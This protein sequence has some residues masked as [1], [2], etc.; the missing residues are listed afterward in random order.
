MDVTISRLRDE[1]PG[2][3]GP[4]RLPTLTRLG[5]E[6]AN[7]YM[8]TGPGLPAA[9]PDLSA[10]IE[11][12]REAYGLLGGA[13]P[14]R[15][16]SAGQLGNLLAY[17]FALHGT[18]SEDRDTA[19]AMLGEAL[20]SGD[21]P[22][23]HTMV[24]QLQLGQLHLTY[25]TES[26]SPTAVRGCFFGGLPDSAKTGA[27]EAISC[28][29]A[30][31]DGPPIS[32]DVTA[33]ARALL[34]VAESIQP[35]LAGDL[36]RFDTSKIMDAMAQLQRLRRD[37]LP[38]LPGMAAGSGLV[39]SVAMPFSLGTTVDPIDYPV[40][41]IHGDAGQPPTVPAR[42][43][44]STDP[45]T[46]HDP[47]T[48]HDPVTA[49]DP[50]AR[51]VVRARLAALTDDAARPVWEQALDLLY[52]DPEAVPPGDLDTFVGAAAG[53]VDGTFADPVA[54]AV[55]DPI[56][57]GLDRLL[58]AVGLCA[59]HRRDGDGDGWG[60][61]DRD[62]WSGV[63]DDS[64]ASG[65]RLTAAKQLRAAA[66]LIPATHP[67]AAVVVTALGGLADDARPLSGPT[68]EIADPL[69]RY[70]D[71]IPD[72][73]A[74]VTAIGELCRTVTA[75][76]TGTTLDPEPFAAAVAALPTD[77]P[78][79]RQLSTAV[80]HARLAVA[81]R[82]GDA[83][84]V[85]AELATATAPAGLAALLEAVVRDDMATL[86]TAVDAITASP[87]RPTTRI[88]AIIGAVRLELAIRA[89]DPGGGDVTAAI[90]LLTTA[91]QALDDIADEGLRTRTWWRL[92]AAYRCRGDAG[93]SELCR[94]AGRHALRGAGRYPRRAARYAGWMLAE[95]HATEAFAALE[96]TAAMSGRADV[97]SL[98][99]D[100][101]SV[102]VGVAPQVTGPVTVPTPAEA[103][104]A[105]REI[106][107][108]SLLYLH[109]T[110]DA[111]RNAAALCVDPATDR[112]DVLANVPVTD[113]LAS[114][115][116]G[117]PAIVGRWT[118]GSLLLAST[119]GLERIALPAVRTGDNQ[120]LTQGVV[121]S[122]VSSGAEAITL[123]ARPA[124]AVDAAPL[125]VVNPRGD[126]DADMVE[127]LTLRRLFYP[128]SVCLGRALEPADAAGTRGELLARMPGASMVHLAC[129]LRRDGRTELQLADDDVLTA[130]AIRSLARTVGGGL[131]VLAEPGPDGFHADADVF[132]DAGFA[133]VI[134]WRWP[135]PAPFAALA[136]FMTHLMLVDHRLPP[137]AAVAAV[138][139]WMLD[140]DRSLPQ[141]VTT[142]QLHTV[143]TIDLTRPSFWAALACRGR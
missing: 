92:A 121:V 113:P 40:T 103:A 45:V 82:A 129:G 50:T 57:S 51:Q 31:V 64:S 15:G 4:A 61:R 83:D 14:A 122:H 18:G 6:Y 74:T 66:T 112:L 7:R 138:H 119:G 34:T 120:F 136:L 135:V 9:L 27:A 117:W 11:A 16:Q 35:L 67:A 72:P 58:F 21:L 62:G 143:A 142:A 25:A 59:R 17:R 76:R 36:A 44:P 48:A 41:V 75:I 87:A 29:R 71:R 65:V 3:R 91:N 85:R 56:E 20:A 12:W 1:L 28:F 134:G 97:D 63:D 93:D 95:G 69:G 125:F 52:V 89:P 2:L 37:G 24:F 118:A 49:D 108:A 116:P 107:A 127:V 47:G 33:T 105:V 102:A 101:V 137:P 42:R 139:R 38:G 141:F 32:A 130:T 88:A 81:V 96:A 22:P 19:L 126:R 60:D 86:R 13:D 78:W 115:D 99:A 109:P 79:H 98:T 90:R 53:T 73:P 26:M 124:S 54:A 5:Q 80:G 8:R 30:V 94:D 70:A 111:G 77:H 106:G 133:G 104:A 68:T 46:A 23:T 132:V 10:A 110:D 123:A 84:A 114:D 100:V 43:Q 131:V 128:N 55:D 140:P 39:S